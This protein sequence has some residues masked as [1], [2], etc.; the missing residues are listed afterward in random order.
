MDIGLGIDRSI[1]L[2]CI[3]E[4][5]SVKVWAECNLRRTISLGK[6]FIVLTHCNRSCKISVSHTV[7]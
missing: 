7:G 1:I 5:W 2:I 6:L 3:I 4:G